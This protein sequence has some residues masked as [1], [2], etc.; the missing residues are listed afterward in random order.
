MDPRVSSSVSIFCYF[1]FLI[2][3]LWQ[4]HFHQAMK[5]FAVMCC[6]PCISCSVLAYSSICT[7]R[8][9]WPWL[10][11][12]FKHQEN[13]IGQIIYGIFELF[14]FFFPR[15][16]E[17]GNVDGAEEQKQRIEQLQRERRKVLQDNNMTHKPRFFKYVTSF[18][19]DNVCALLAIWWTEYCVDCWTVASAG[20]PTMIPGW[21]TTCTGICAESLA[22]VK[23]TSQSCG[24][25]WI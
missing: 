20:S 3:F 8:L 1:K 5:Q 19:N 11:K 6:I 4:L 10:E 13:K 15:F 25:L 22:S 23:L 9:I 14:F 7:A 2:V 24:D 21:A 17:E 12:L 18:S 16:L